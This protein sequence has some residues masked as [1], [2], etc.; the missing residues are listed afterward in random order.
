VPRKNSLKVNDCD[1]YSI[2]HDD[3][4]FFDANIWV[5]ILNRDSSEE[6]YAY[7]AQNF[8]KRIHNK[9]SYVYIC[10][11][12]I[13]EV[14]NNLIQK[15]RHKSITLGRNYKEFRK[16]DICQEWVQDFADQFLQLIKSGNVKFI[17]TSIGPEDTITYLQ[18]KAK[19][20][21]FKDFIY[22]HICYKEDLILVTNDRDFAISVGKVSKILSMDK[23]LINRPF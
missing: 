17:N 12:I 2:K 10:P 8:L 16:S 20:L 22:E 7:K 1:S 5:V 23:T 21:D 18:T 11:E 19:F 3:K 13:S 9:G 15:E 4:F 14:F 6:K